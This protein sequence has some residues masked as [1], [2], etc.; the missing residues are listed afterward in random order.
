M[1]CEKATSQRALNLSF[2]LI[3]KTMGV[4]ETVKLGSFSVGN[5][6]LTGLWVGDNPEAAR[7]ST[8][9]FHVRSVA[10]LTEASTAW[11]GSEEVRMSGMEAQ[12]LT[13]LRE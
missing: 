1:R 7:G 9:E 11:R 12:E 3:L 8:T 2:N 13:R 10:G 5:S 6:A 4:P